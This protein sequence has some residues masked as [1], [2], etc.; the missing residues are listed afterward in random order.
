[1]SARHYTGFQRIQTLSIYFK[2]NTVLLFILSSI[3]P[4]SNGA[5]YAKTAQKLQGRRG[6]AR[7]PQRNDRHVEKERKPFTVALILSDSNAFWGKHK[8][9]VNG[10]KV[11]EFKGDDKDTGNK[12]SVTSIVISHVT[13]KV[14]E[15]IQEALDNQNIENNTTNKIFLDTKK[16]VSKIVDA[17]LSTLVVPMS[18]MTVPENGEFVEKLLTQHNNVENIEISESASTRVWTDKEGNEQVNETET[19]QYS[20]D[21]YPSFDSL[22]YNE[23]F[24]TYYLS[25]QRKELTEEDGENV[26]EI[27]APLKGGANHH[28]VKHLF[29]L[30]SIDRKEHNDLQHALYTIGS[31]KFFEKPSAS[32]I[33]PKG[34][35]R[36]STLSSISRKHTEIVNSV[37]G[38]IS[39]LKDGGKFQLTDIYGL[40]TTRLVTEGDERVPKQFNL[41][42]KLVK[43][44]EV[45]S[46]TSTSKSWQ[47]GE[48]PVPLTKY[49]E[50]LAKVCNAVKILSTHLTPLKGELFRVFNVDSYLFSKVEA[51]EEIEEEAEAE[52]AHVPLVRNMC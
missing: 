41:I 3:M 50:Y 34:G 29:S 48:H 21:Y 9:M 19:I 2:A 45:M 26:L 28:L 52:E 35:R 17:V 8:E 1:M 13:P 33:T 14:L 18:L 22:N 7:F 39:L 11:S 37:A 5:S 20:F 10:L 4:L 6:N 25:L 42:G 31:F 47:S 44:E 30:G 40:N 27:H 51:E 15:S 36:N 23:K 46:T 43:M 38:L 32:Q 16:E 24:G 12:F 49:L